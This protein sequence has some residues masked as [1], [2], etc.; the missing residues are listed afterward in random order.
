GQN[1]L[2]Y[3]VLVSI[4]DSPPPLEPAM[5]DQLAAV[6]LSFAGPLPT[7]TEQAYERA[8]PIYGAVHWCWLRLAGGTAERDLLKAI[9]A[10]VPQEGEVLDAG[11]GGGRLA[12]RVNRLRPRVRL[13]MVDISPGM[14]SRAADV[15]GERI[16]GNVLDLPLEDE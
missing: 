11:C 5:P 4:V 10:G 1:Q 8:A 7:G 13:T 12:R 2:R 9:A 14:L 15:P 16:C 6:R 3:V